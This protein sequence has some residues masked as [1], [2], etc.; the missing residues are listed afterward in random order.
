M[1]ATFIL[2]AYCRNPEYIAKEVHSTPLHT[3]QIHLAAHCCLLLIAVTPVCVCVCVC[4][5]A[6]MNSC[7]CL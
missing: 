3:Q 2:N 5:H 7:T 1:S 6:C 4:K